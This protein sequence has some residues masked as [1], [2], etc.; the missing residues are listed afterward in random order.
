MISSRR[1]Y[2]E[3]KAKVGLIADRLAGVDMVRA[4]SLRELLDAIVAGAGL[5]PRD[6][7]RHFSRS[8]PVV[9]RSVLLVEGH[10]ECGWFCACPEGW[11][12]PLCPNCA[13]LV[14]PPGAQ[15]RYAGDHGARMAY[16][17]TYFPEG[18]AV[19]RLA[20]LRRRERGEGDE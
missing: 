9:G 7:R 20:E 8:A 5:E 11:L 16:V 2:L 13:R 4:E 1:R 15:T 18:D 19:D 6:G 17:A 10:C 14:K 3:L 12:W